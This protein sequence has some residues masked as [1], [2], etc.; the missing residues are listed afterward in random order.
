MTKIEELKKK[1]AGT[2]DQRQNNATKNNSPVVSGDIKTLEEEV[3]KQVCKLDKKCDYKQNIQ[4]F[5]V[6]LSYIN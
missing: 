5:V 3:A 6:H 1:F 2:Q 4:V